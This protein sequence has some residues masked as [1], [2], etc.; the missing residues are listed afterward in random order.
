[1]RIKKAFATSALLILSG[2]LAIAVLVFGMALRGRRVAMYDVS[3][4]LTRID[5]QDALVVT[6]P[7]YPPWGPPMHLSQ[8]QFDYGRHEILITRYAAGFPGISPDIYNRLPLVIMRG[9]LPGVYEVKYWSEQG[10]SDLG[11]LTVEEDFDLSYLAAD[12]SQR[13][14]H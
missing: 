8:V 3:A 10:Y 7:E 14:N 12:S 2:L 13:G 4:S 1:M 11:R 9:L 6:S 5:G